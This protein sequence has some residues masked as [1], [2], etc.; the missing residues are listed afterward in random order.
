MGQHKTLGGITSGAALVFLI[1]PI[2][3]VFWSRY[4]YFF[5]KEEIKS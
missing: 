1:Y 3:S 2:T 4:M 5:G